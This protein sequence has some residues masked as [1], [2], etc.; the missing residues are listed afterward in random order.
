MPTLDTALTL[1]NGVQMPLIGFG[2][3]ALPEGKNGQE[4]IET[5]LECGYRHCRHPASIYGNEQLVG[6]ARSQSKQDRG[7]LFLTTKL[8]EDEQGASTTPEALDRSL[9]KLPTDYVDFYLIHWPQP[10]GR[11]PANAGRRGRPSWKA[12]AAERSAFPTSVLGV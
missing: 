3:Y 1:G 10:E 9:Q 12:G 11:R 6:D 2:A 8:W 7:K 4:A 5:A